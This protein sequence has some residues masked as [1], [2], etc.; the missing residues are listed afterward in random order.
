MNKLNEQ[1][2]INKLNKREYKIKEI[3]VKYQDG[4]ED[5]IKDTE[6][7]AVIFANSETF[8]TEFMN[9]TEK[10]YIDYF[11]TVMNSIIQLGLEDDVLEN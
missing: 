6:V 11:K 4:H 2:E 5:T 3:I 7:G 8:M 10:D 1:T 9:F